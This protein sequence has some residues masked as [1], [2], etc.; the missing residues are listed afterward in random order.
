MTEPQTAASS[1]PAPPASG[2]RGFWSLFVTQFQN[3]FSD[4]T[5]KILAIF[6][7]IAVE[8]SPEKRNVLVTLVQAMFALPFVL[9]SMAGGFL[10]DR[11]S[12]RKVILGIKCAEIG[13]MSLATIGL[14]QRNV[15]L[16]LAGIFL[17][18]THSA[19]FGPSKYG[20]LPELLPEKKLSWGNGMIQL[21]TFIAG[22]AGTVA[23]GQFSDRFGM[24]QHWSGFILV[25][26]ALFGI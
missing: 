19:F 26:C 13:I 12:K 16:L 17:M 15:P 6:I 22:I 25:G 10:A 7:I 14:W 5:L 18:S 11:F 1:S 21:G 4:N 3:A 24:D 23:A 20:L 8:Q 2:L 9:F